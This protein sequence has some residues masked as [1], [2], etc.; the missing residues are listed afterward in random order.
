MTPEPRTTIRRAIEWFDFDET[1]P[2]AEALTNVILANLE[3]KGW[4]FCRSVEC[5]AGPA[6]SEHAWAPHEVVE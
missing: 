4:R 1:P 3:A 2:I 5:E 6:C